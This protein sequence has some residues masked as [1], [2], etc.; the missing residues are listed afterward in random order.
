MHLP[1]PVDAGQEGWSYV[2]IFFI[3]PPELL[4]E[5]ELSVDSS[6]FPVW[7]KNDSSFLSN[8]HAPPVLNS[9]ERQDLVNDREDTVPVTVQKEKY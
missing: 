6:P 9:E 2:P 8:E 3:Y 4:R 5:Q 1:P 7:Q